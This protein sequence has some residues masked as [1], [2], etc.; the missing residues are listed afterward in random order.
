MNYVLIG[1]IIYIILNIIAFVSYVWDK[2]KAKNDQWRTR[3]S[4]LITLAFFGPFGAT[5][6]MLAVRHKTQKIKFKLVYIF[7]VLHIIL[8]AYLVYAG[9]ISFDSL[10]SF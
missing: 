5:A 9:Y 2:H 4:T 7:L 10:T 3:E 8:I 1:L 6:G